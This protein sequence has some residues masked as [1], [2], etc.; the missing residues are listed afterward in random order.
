MQARNDLEIHNYIIS[1]GNTMA[2]ILMLN[3]IE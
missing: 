2:T 3:D 1:K